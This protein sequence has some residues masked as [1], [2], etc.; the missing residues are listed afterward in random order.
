VP[1]HTYERMPA[2]PLTVKQSGASLDTELGR[3]VP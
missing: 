3:S 1:I 2:E